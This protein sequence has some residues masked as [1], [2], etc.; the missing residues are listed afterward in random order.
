M[1]N[2]VTIETGARLHFGLLAV[3]P[4]R[5]REF[6]G[7]GVMLA[8]P[9]FQLTCTP[10]TV[11]RVE[12]PLPSTSQRVREF[13]SRIRQAWPH[14]L[15]S[16]QIEVLHEIESHGG[17]GSGTQLGLAVAAGV[18]AASGH[19]PLPATE[20][21][22]L[23]GR[24]ER[25]AIGVHGFD[26]GGFLIEAGKLPDEPLSP[27]VAHIPFPEDWR[28]VLVSPRHRQGLSG[29]AEQ[30]TFRQLSPMPDS[31]T[32]TLCRLVLMDWWPA[33]LARDFETTSEVLW[34]YGQ[35]VGEYFAP[36][37]GGRFAD[38]QME[39][40]AE[41]LRTEGI[42]GIAQTS[43]GPTIAILCAAPESAES[44]VSALQQAPEG[45]ECEL[46]ITAA[47]NRGA[48]LEIAD[49]SPRLGK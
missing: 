27:L 12:S 6:G 7:V 18:L 1:A 32:G 20:L 41:R 33:L 21:A 16:L 14:P 36:A 11:D 37:Q 2:L 35:R 3:H 44:L 28:W 24:G 23:V 25:S 31:L 26:L 38:P 8:H 39:Q 29:T 4:P 19:P 49:T 40:L 30:Q 15:P 45:N 5:G 47:R 10:A 9:G 22:R 13:L 48:T 42:R 34:E 17:L 43:W 46:R